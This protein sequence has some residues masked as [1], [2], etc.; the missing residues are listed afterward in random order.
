LSI[1]IFDIDDFKKV[2]DTKGHIFGDQVLIEVAELIRK[3][4]RN[5]DHV[6]RYGG[7]EFMSFSPI[8]RQPKRRKFQSGSGKRLKSIIF[9]RIQDYNQW[10]CAAI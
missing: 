3:N 1:A 10:R 7:E 5:Y 2:N 4:V 8:Q 6:G 9:R